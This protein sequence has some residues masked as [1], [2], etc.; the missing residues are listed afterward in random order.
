MTEQQEAP[1]DVAVVTGGRNERR[2]R[3]ARSGISTP[4]STVPRAGQLPGRHTALVLTRLSA[5][6]SQLH[7]IRAILPDERGL[8]GRLTA[9]EEEL[10]TIGQQVLVG[11]AVDATP[12]VLAD[13]AVAADGEEPS[14][15]ERYLLGWL[16]RCH[17][18]GASTLTPP[19]RDGR[20]MRTL[21]R[22]LT[23]SRHRLPPDIRGRFGLSEQATIGDVAMELL[24]AVDGPDG[25]HCRSYRSAVYYLAG[26]A[27]LAGRS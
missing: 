8:H 14:D 2:T 20:S 7:G 9:V 15:V 12:G 24:L 13:D 17:G 5:V 22:E 10:E 27:E 18:S 23:S 11:P 3:P 4:T 26:R 16:E 21:L 19:V 25:P 6:V 1:S